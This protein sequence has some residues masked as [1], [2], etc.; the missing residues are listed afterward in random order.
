MED[1]SRGWAPPTYRVDEHG[2]VIGRRND[3]VPH[4]WGRWGD[5]DERGTTNFITADRL[6]AATRLVVTGEVVGCAIPIGEEMPVHPSRPSVVHTHWLTGADL[7]AGLVPDRA[8]GGFYGADDH[9]AMPL[10]SA[11]HWDGLSHAFHQDT[12]YNGFWIGTVGAAGG[13]RRCSTH[14]LADRLVGRGVLLD[15][16][17]DQGVDRLSPGHA[18]T[19]DQLDSCAARQGVEVRTGDILLV[20][21]GELPWFYSLEDKTPYWTGNHAGL[22]VTTVDWIYT[23]QVAAVALDNRTFEVTPF[24]K[25]YDVTYPLHSR[26][27]RDLGLTIGELWWLEDLAATCARLDRWEFLLT[28]PPLP[29]TGASGASTTPLAFF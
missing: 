28:A 5:L 25:P 13:A 22:S 19:T 8:A 9:L 14:L 23:H 11:T 17:R 16:P 12:M 20:R 6:R 18:I 1:W 15:L 26:L 4:N 7:V 24:E 2:K 10:Q 27:I 21:T 29:V 3:R